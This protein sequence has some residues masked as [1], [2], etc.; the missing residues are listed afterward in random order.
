VSII[1]F[2]A[3]VCEEARSS[4]RHLL[5]VAGT[6]EGCANF[7]RARQTSQIDRAAATANHICKTKGKNKETPRA[8]N[9]KHA[10][11][12]T[13]SEARCGLIE[14]QPDRALL[15]AFDANRFDITASDQGRTNIYTQLYTFVPDKSEET[16]TTPDY[17]LLAVI[18]H[19]LLLPS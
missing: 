17:H 7:S 2:F 18:K 9:K 14:K 4:R 10:A 1:S 19:C 11:R 15:P 12:R 5:V 6:R 16:N 8:V 13:W 3:D